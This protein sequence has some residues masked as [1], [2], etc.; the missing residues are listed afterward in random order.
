MD[1]FQNGVAAEIAQQHKED[2]DPGTEQ[3]RRVDG[4]LHPVILLGAEQLGDYHRA[5]YVAAE[6]KGNKNEGYFIAVP[7]GSQ[8]VLTHEL[9]RYQAVRNVVELLEDNAA[10]KG[11]AESPEHCFRTACGQILVQYKYTYFSHKV[12]RHIPVPGLL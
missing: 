2:A 6:G 11:Q 5:A 1:G 3:P 9:S 12:C 4:G 10:E 8:S 7:D